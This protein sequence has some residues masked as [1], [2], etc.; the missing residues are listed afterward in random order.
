MNS[1]LIYQHSEFPLIKTVENQHTFA[2]I[3]A[4][5]LEEI[6]YLLLVGI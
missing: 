1:Q 4:E 5:I 3:T 6:V 2:I